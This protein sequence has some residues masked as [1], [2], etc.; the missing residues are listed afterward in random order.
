MTAIRV[1][2]DHQE[3]DN[4]GQVPHSDLDTYITGSAFLVVSGSGPLPPSGRRLVA[5]AGIVITDGGPG[6][7]LTISAPG[8]AGSAI[9]WAEVPGGVPDGVTT[10]FTLAHTPS[11]T[12]A[13]MFFINGVLQ[14]Q[15]SDS[16][17]TVISGSIIHILYPYRSGSNLTAMYPY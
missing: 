3:L 13:L 7:N 4:S 11:P 1:V 15:G 16:D 17:Y 6:G 12:S 2:T 8:A 10:D 14:R 5:G 9:A